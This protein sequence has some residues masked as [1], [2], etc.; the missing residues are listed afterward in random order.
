M[1]ICPEWPF[2]SQFPGLLFP[3]G[4]SYRFVRETPLN[5]KSGKINPYHIPGVGKMIAT[6][7]NYVENFGN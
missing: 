5:R 4:I 7:K 3:G 1:H 6:I 2:L